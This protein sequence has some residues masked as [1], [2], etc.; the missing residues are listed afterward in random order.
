M[1]CPGSGNHRV[2][3][4]STVVESGAWQDETAHA[5]GM[6]RWMR[7]ATGEVPCGRLFSGEA[8]ATLLRCGRRGVILSVPTGGSEM[9]DLVIRNGTVV[10]G[11]GL[12]KYR[13]DV[14]VTGDRIAAIGRIHRKRQRGNRRHGP[15]GD[16]GFHRRAHAHGRPG[17]LGSAG[18]L[19]LLARRH[20]RR[21]GELR[22]HARAGQG[23]AARPDRE[24]HSAGRGHQ[25]Q[26]D[27]GR[28]Q[29]ELDDVQGV[30]GR[31]RQAAEDDQLRRQ[32][33]P[34]GAAHA[35]HGRARV[36]AAGH[37]R[38]HGRDGARAARRA[39]RRRDRLYQLPLHGP[40]AAAAGQPLRRFVPRVVGG[41]VPARMPH[42]IDRPRHI[43]VFP[44]AGLAARRIRRCGRAPTTGCSTS[45]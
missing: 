38:R 32:H 29:L 5:C 13:A 16:A 7:A 9:Y 45:P 4:A 39:R 18:K 35:R 6:Q 22:L 43:R 12:P 11:T 42:G 19:L 30:H 21:H 8:R 15:R 26:G 1:R 14:G 34:L 10:D 44:G 24:Q 20:D 33:R 31:R 40:P 37:C 27:G 17:V 25:P 2:T 41:D 23:Q 28:D 36:R 3:H